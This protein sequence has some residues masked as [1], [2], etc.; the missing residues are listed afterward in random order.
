MS[1]FSKRQKEIFLITVASIFL[2]SLSLYTYYVVFS[3]A[4]DA[5]DQQKVSVDN[6]RAVLFALRT[7]VAEKEDSD[8][9]STLNYQQKLPVKPLQDAILL[10]IAKAETKSGTQIRNVDFVQSEFEIL[11]PP[12]HVE[13]VMELLTTV[14]IEVVDYPSLVN[15]IDEIEQMERIFVID[16]IQFQ[17]PD[18]V[19]EVETE[20]E[21][22]VLDV[23]FSAFYRA[24]LENLDQEA[25]KINAP[26][27]SQKTTPFTFNDGGE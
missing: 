24:D 25:P 18:E 7:E 10:Q 1:S 15:F 11:D 27:G 14:E 20:Q 12:E 21:T 17:G 26:P 3:P 9:T 2:L 19:T 16:T 4:K 6:E 22:I 5:Y 23:S 8:L 13:N